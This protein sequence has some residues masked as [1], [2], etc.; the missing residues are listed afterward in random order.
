MERIVE[1]KMETFEQPR[2]SFLPR[3]YSRDL[4]YP[5]ECG[6]MLDG[7]LTHNK[8]LEVTKE[9]TTSMSRPTRAANRARKKTQR[10]PSSEIGTFSWAGSIAEFPRTH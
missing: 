6:K 1:I 3:K 4:L 7:E 5:L 10:L 9:N 2:F 8:Q